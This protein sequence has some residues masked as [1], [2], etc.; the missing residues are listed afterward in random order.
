M[1]VPLQL[2]ENPR[3][4][5]VIAENHCGIDKVVSVDLCLYSRVGQ[6]MKRMPR[7]DQTNRWRQDSSVQ[8]LILFKA[9][10]QITDVFV[11]WQQW[12]K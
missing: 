4:R 2:N 7:P 6:K 5:P 11:P 9:A 1:E 8:P 10:I 12:I 3:I